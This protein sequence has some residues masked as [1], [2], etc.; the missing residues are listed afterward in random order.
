LARHVGRDKVDVKAIASPR[1]SVH[2]YHPTPKDIRNV[3]STD[4]YV[5]WGLDIEAWSD[6]LLEAAG[7]SSLF[8]GG[9]GNVDLSKGIELMKVPTGRISRSEGDIH[10]YGNPHY[11]MNPENF[12][13]MARTLADKLKVVDPENAK[14]YDLNLKKFLSELE[15]K[16]ADWKTA[17]PYCQDKEIIAY[18]ED[19]E[20]FARF[21]GLKLEEFVE[22]KP[23]IPPSPQHLEHLKRYANENHIGAITIATYFPKN[24]A[25]RLSEKIGAPVI[26][27]IQNAGEVPGTESIFDFFDYN[28]RQIRGVLQ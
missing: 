18:H 9:S 26:T 27:I 23:G 20:Y 11:H 6:P 14:E 17:C 10:L 22:P 12:R 13:M 3:R 4:L 7:K 24:S 15:Q 25:K 2:F 8:R 16:I 28:V 5:H 1:F 21:M 19:T